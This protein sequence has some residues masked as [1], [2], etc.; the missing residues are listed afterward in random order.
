MDKEK[1]IFDHIKVRKI[2]VPSADYF[3]NLSDAVIEKQ[4]PEIIP[5]YKRPLSWVSAAAAIIVVALLV[6]NMSE[7][8]ISNGVSD[9]LLALNEFSSEELI[10]YIDSNIDDFDTELIAEMIPERDL[11]TVEIFDEIEALI[12]EEETQEAIMP[13]SIEA[14]E[15]QDILDYFNEEGLDLEDFED[16]DIYI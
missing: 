9:P 4:R 8:A 12:I 10:A 15:D 2:D 6:T 7:S 3:K 14:L 11:A 13:V 1:D 16:D 5:L